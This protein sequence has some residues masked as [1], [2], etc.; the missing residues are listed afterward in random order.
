VK[1][2][3]ICLRTTSLTLADSVLSARKP[4]DGYDALDSRD[5]T[6]EISNSSAKVRLVVDP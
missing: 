2:V 1:T 5:T 3:P 4:H 6:H